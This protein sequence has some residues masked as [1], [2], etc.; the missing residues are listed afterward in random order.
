MSS[1]KTFILAPKSLRKETRLII[2]GSI[3]LWPRRVESP[4][5][6][7]INS[8]FLYKQGD[9]GYRDIALDFKTR[10]SETGILKLLANGTSYPG[11]TSQ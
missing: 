5:L 8:S 4:L 11:K 10:V 9:V 2:S 3:K 7:K 6:T 1:G